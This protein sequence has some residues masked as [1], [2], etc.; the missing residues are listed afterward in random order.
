[1]SNLEYLDDFGYAHLSIDTQTRNGEVL[2]SFIE[3]CDAH[4]DERFWQA[5]RNWSEFDK[6]HASNNGEEGGLRDTF[7]FEGKNG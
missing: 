3:Y 6:I 4:E 1:M 5:L 7:Y 2:L